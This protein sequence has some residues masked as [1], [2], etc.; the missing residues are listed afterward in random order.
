MPPIHFRRF[1]LL[2]A[3]ATFALFTGCDMSSTA[4]A[5]GTDDTH[6]GIV[7]IQGRVLTRDA[8]PFG[9]VVVRLRKKNLT[10][11][12]DSEGRFQFLSDSAI[13]ASI[14][15]SAV[16]SVDYLRDGQVVVSVPVPSWTATLPDIMLVQRDLSG[17]V[18]G[19]VSRVAGASCELR[20]PNGTV[21]RIDLEWNTAQRTF[22]GFAY[23][24]YQGGVDS[25]AAIA[26]VR[27]GA[28][29]ILGRSDSVR[30]TSRAG[31]IVFPVFTASNAL[32]E[33]HLRTSKYCSEA[34]GPFRSNCPQDSVQA[35][36]RQSVR[37]FAEVYS[38]QDRFQALEWNL[39]GKHW[40]R[41][42]QNPS[43]EFGPADGWLSQG[44]V[45][46]TTV[47]VPG[48][49]DVGSI[50]PIRARALDTDGTWSEDTLYLRVVRIL[51]FANAYLKGDHLRNETKV[52]IPAGSQTDLILGDSGVGGAGIVSRKVYLHR[53]Q[54][55][56]TSASCLEPPTFDFH[57]GQT[58]DVPAPSS[59]PSFFRFAP[60]LLAGGNDMGRPV[61]GKDTILTLPSLPG[62][63]RL[64]YEV[65]DS[66]GDTTL[67]RSTLA[68]LRPAAPRIDSIVVSAD[69]IRIDWSASR[70]TVETQAD[71]LATRWILTARWIASDRIDSARTELPDTSRSVVLHPPSDMISMRFTL[72]RT[73][74][75][76][77]GFL[78]DTAITSPPPLRLT[79]SGSILDR[80]RLHG[81]IHSRGGA[82]AMLSGS[83]G[84]NLRGEVARFS[85]FLEDSTD[86]DA[87]AATFSLPAHRGALGLELDLDAPVAKACRIALLS[88]QDKYGTN[89]L[90]QKSSLGWDVPAGFAGHLVLSLD[91]TR[92][93]N[94]TSSF[95]ST[96]LDRDAALA[97]IQGIAI[98]VEARQGSPLS[99]G[100]MEIDNLVWK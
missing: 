31:D 2:G 91:S 27:D 75:E 40:I 55:G 25:F 70:P 9:N 43:M 82:R 37:I 14:S 16:D 34:W 94:S 41:S 57:L 68:D 50:W 49:L 24:R 86:N 67:V 96:G 28:D 62:L 81:S 58:I 46:D 66:D 83:V 22:G 5:G 8:R 56:D 13:Q 95:D 30:F 92:W 42:S 44:P 59:C 21:Q 100:E 11:T 15:A 64:W 18:I 19:D 7:N 29:R 63:Y 76:I 1:H 23:F 65:V 10:D 47:A 73:S 3:I 38:N 54:P 26:E 61:S 39:D 77:D 32:P 12:T 98:L 45:Y 60:N 35:G 84:T 79:F 20:L 48:N 87:V 89:A 90:D 78:A 97:D 52:I 71:F 93:Q 6:T 69:S 72:T 36:V 53:A 80:D 33:I 51:P 17:S 99:A 88:S 85:W 74:G 4:T